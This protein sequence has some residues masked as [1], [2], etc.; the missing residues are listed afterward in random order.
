MDPDRSTEI[1]PENLAQCSARWGLL[2]FAWVNVGLGMIG[3]V[4]PG[5]LNISRFN[6]V[7]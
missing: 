3:V 7:M 6:P 1:K 5:M 4:I 2:A